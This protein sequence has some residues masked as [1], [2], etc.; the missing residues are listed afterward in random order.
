MKRLLVVLVV[1]VAVGLFALSLPDPATLDW[2][3][4]QSWDS[5]STEVVV[6]PAPEM[7]PP[8]AHGTIGPVYLFHR[9]LDDEEYATLYNSGDGVQRSAC[10]W[11]TEEEG[12][13][14]L[15]CW[16]LS[17][18]NEPTRAAGAVQ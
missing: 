16:D 4:D 7:L 6:G 12:L 18:V 9:A 5:S 2:S 17:E 14:I 3:D 8:A 10:A 15:S 11:V 13:P 1:F